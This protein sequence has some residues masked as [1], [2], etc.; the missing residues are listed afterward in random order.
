MSALTEVELADSATNV[1]WGGV[2]R[3]LHRGSRTTSTNQQHS[4]VDIF[5]LIRTGTPISAQRALAESL[6]NSVLR[7]GLVISRFLTPCVHPYQNV[8]TPPR[9][10]RMARPLPPPAEPPARMLTSWTTGSLP[11]I[12]R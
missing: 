10:S 9:L 11:R 12:R 7:K 8:R 6:R 2:R 3:L 4:D 5:I 1:F